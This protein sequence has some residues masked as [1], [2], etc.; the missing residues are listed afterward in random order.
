MTFF[1]Y[2]ENKHSYKIYIYLAYQKLSHLN[3]KMQNFSDK[4]KNTYGITVGTDPLQCDESP[5]TIVKCANY[6]RRPI[7]NFTSVYQ[8]KLCTV[9]IV[10][11]ISRITF[12]CIKVSR[13]SDPIYYLLYNQ[14]E[15]HFSEAYT[16]KA[17]GPQFIWPDFCWSSICY[18]DIRNHYSYEFIWKIVPLE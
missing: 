4:V 6:N 14:C 5:N 1:K 2:N 16:D 15:V 11:I 18:K 3:T 7:Q 12:A 8:I 13:S 10:L 17:N 9:R